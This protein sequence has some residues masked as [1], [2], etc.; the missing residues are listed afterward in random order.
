MLHIQLA[1]TELKKAE[2]D[3]VKVKVSIAKIQRG[4]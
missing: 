1:D 4:T 2:P 3:V